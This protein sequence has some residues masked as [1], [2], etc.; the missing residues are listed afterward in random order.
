M[1]DYPIKLV[2]DAENNA[3]AAL[4]Q[5]DKDVAGLETSTKSFST[6]LQDLKPQFKAMATAGAIGFG[7]VVAIVGTSVKAFGEAEKEIAR[8]DGM[9]KT[10]SKE[11]LA[12]TGMSFDEVRQKTLDFGIS[13]MKLSGV[14]DELASVGLTKLFQITKDYTKA[15][16]GAMLAADLAAYKQIDYST[17]VDIVGKVYNGNIGILARYGIV[18][19]ENATKEE[20]IAQLMAMTAGQAEAYGNT[21][22]GQ[23]AI[24][25]ESFSNLQETIG[26][27]FAPIL[28]N[29]LKSLEPV[30]AKVMEWVQVNPELVKWILIVVGAISGLLLI[31]RTLG[32]ALPAI[33]TG[34]T[35]LGSALMLLL[36]NPIVLLIALI[37]ALVIYWIKNWTMLKDN[38]IFIFEII[39]KGISDAMNFIRDT[40]MGVINPI[41][42]A[43]EDFLARVNKV[44]GAV[45]S[46][47]GAI[48]GGIVSTA[49]SIIGAKQYGGYIP[50]T[51]AYML[52]RGEYVSR[53]GGGGGAVS[54]TITGNT[55]LS[56]DA[57]VRMGDLI[58]KVLQRGIR[59]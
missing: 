6:Q 37:G 57:A 38:I 54:L 58:I 42:S 3:S 28:I 13:L 1:A 36:A 18:L 9:L 23:M 43:I 48:G 24:M 44:V 49:K 51:G 26:A 20:A 19:D 32:L 53:A 40:I 4:K 33:I 34:V 30:V 25:K 59:I 46:V 31:I 47:A 41:I 27:V 5:I 14:S 21:F 17:A 45:K 39:K 35:M 16:A 10:V 52:H 56:E 22:Q 15:Q 8:M 12:K 55:F 50:E 7:A 2:V 29:I 11:T